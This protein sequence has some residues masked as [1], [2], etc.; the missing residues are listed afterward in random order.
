MND[1]QHGTLKDHSPLTA[2]TCIQNLLISG[3]EERTLTSILLIDLT[4]AYEM[5]DH[6]TLD[7]K[8][9]AYNFGEGI[10]GW[11]KATWQEEPKVL[12]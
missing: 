8:L 5:I 1:E 2:T 9:K 7:K 12:K 6:D 3:A 4:A 11:I 10:G